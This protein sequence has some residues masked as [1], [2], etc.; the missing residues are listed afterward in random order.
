MS[1]NYKQY[2]FIF[3]VS[4]L[5]KTTF[6]HQ[7]VDGDQ[8]SNLFASRDQWVQSDCWSQFDKSLILT[9][10][11]YEKSQMLGQGPRLRSFI[12]QFGNQLTDWLPPPPASRAGHSFLS[13]SVSVERTMVLSRAVQ[14]GSAREATWRIEQLLRTHFCYLFIV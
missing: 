10:W 4:Y 9:W 7:L 6:Q 14:S 5:T 11:D 3:T 13:L 2:M 12:S 1:R 8:G